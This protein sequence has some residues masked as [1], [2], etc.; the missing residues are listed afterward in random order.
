MRKYKNMVARI[1]GILALVVLVSSV[2]AARIITSPLPDRVIDAE[3]PVTELPV[4]PDLVGVRASGG[5]TDVGVGETVHLEAQVDIDDVVTGVVWDV[6]AGLGDPVMLMPADGGPPI[7]NPADRENYQVAGR[8]TFVPAAP[9]ATTIGATIST[10]DAR[11]DVYVTITISAGLYVGAGLDGDQSEEPQCAACHDSEWEHRVTDWMGT[12]HADLL[13]RGLDGVASDHYGEHCISCHSVGHDDTAAGNGGFDDVATALGWVFPDPQEGNWDN[14]LIVPRELKQV[15]NIQCESCH[16]PGSVHGV[17]LDAEGKREAIAVSYDVGACAVCHDSGTHHVRPSEW[18]MSPHAHVPARTTGSCA[19]CHT[20]NGFV[21]A[22]K[23]AD[24]RAGDETIGCAACHDPH[25]AENEHQVR[26]T[27]DVTMGDNATVI[28][29]GGLGKLCMN[30]HKGRRDTATYVLENH[31]HYGPHH[32]PQ[33]DLL[34]GANAADFGQFLPSSSG[35]LLAIENSCSTCHMQESDAAQDHDTHV[36]MAGSHTFKMVLEGDAHARSDEGLH[37]T[38]VCTTCHGPQDSFDIA[39]YKD[40]D[41]DGVV[42]EGVQSEIGQLLEELGMMLPPY[43]DPAVDDPEDDYTLAQLSAVFNYFLVEE[44]G[45]HGIHNPQFAANL[46][47][48]SI[49][50]LEGDGELAGPLGG[51]EVEG[52]WVLSSWFGY[53]SLLFEGWIFHYLHGPLY[54]GAL[55]DDFVQLYDPVI[56]KWMVAA[57]DSYPDVM[58]FWEGNALREVAFASMADGTRVFTDAITG[59][60]EEYPGFTFVPADMT[61]GGAPTN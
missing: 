48:A 59:E 2:Q 25:S 57:P 42:P 7:Y 37:I 34:V 45:S 50:A 47:H 5:L 15:G 53:Y 17:T 21:A 6:V 46:L 28:T 26:T 29:D 13:V 22:T 54:V 60:T 32:G 49:A 23:D 33:A 55:D 1:S 27:A 30:C 12:G 11:G 24:I 43:D 19:P 41:G 20:G 40:F 14:D 51:T 3:D 56:G 8:K 36:Y 39:T 52:G 18:Q 35:H 4:Y 38:E 9:G 10:A 31:G 16:G 44:D 58:W 61:P